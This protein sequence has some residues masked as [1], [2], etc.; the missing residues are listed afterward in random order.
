M[1]VAQGHLTLTGLPC[2]QLQ[3]NCNNGNFANVGLP[4]I[5]AIYGGTITGVSAC[6][7]FY[8]L[9]WWSVWLEFTCIVLS[10]LLIWR[11]IWSKVEAVENL[12]VY[13]FVIS[14]ILLFLIANTYTVSVYVSTQKNKGTYS[15]TSGTSLVAAGSIGVSDLGSYPL[16][17]RLP[18]TS[19]SLTISFQNL[20][21]N[22]VYII[23]SSWVHVPTPPGWAPQGVPADVKSFPIDEDLV[24]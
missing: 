12:T 20:I 8:G 14:S 11:F 16:N 10:S 17:L 21:L 24:D 1:D 3:S 7:N 4:S 18:Q 6:S 15:M 5:S 22:F 19:H 2:F 23:W 9:L 13:F